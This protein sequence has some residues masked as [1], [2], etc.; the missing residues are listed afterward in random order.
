VFML[1]QV[2]LGISEWRGQKEANNV[3]R[4]NQLPIHTYVVREVAKGSRTN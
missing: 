3:D 2:C 1:G 4:S